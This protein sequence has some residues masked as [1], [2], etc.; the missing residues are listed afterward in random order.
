[1]AV[2]IIHYAEPEFFRREASFRKEGAARTEMAES[3]STFRMNLEISSRIVLERDEEQ[4]NRES[5]PS[6][7]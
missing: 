7:I 5:T 2:S 1:M 3:S 6:L 4:K